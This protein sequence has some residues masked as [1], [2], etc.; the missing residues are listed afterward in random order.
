M[1]TFIIRS[2]L[3][4]VIAIL[5]SVGVFFLISSYKTP[6]SPVGTVKDTAAS[7]TKAA[8]TAVKEKAQSTKF[9]IPDKGIPLSKLKLNDEQKSLLKKVGID[10]QTFVPTKDMVTCATQKLGEERIASITAGA[11]PSILE[12]TRLLPCLGA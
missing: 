2:I 7:S 12:V 3:F 1:K 10:A 8:V 5:V 11:P 9:V 6:A 4:F